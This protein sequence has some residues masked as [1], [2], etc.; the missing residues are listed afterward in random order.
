ME[1]EIVELS[2]DSFTD[3]FLGKGEYR[4]KT[5][6]VPGA[7][8]GERIRGK[9]RSREEG[10]LIVEPTEILESSPDR[11]EPE[12]GHF[13][14]CGGCQLQHVAYDRQ[15]ALKKARFEK[16]FRERAPDLKVDINSVIPSDTPYRY[17]NRITLHGPGEPG[18]WQVEGMDMVR[19]EEC[20][21]TLKHLENRLKERRQSHFHSYLEKGIRNVVIRAS[22]TGEVF[23][24]REN[25]DVGAHHAPV[26]HEE[27]T[28]PVT[29]ETLTFR[30]P[31]RSFW[32]A[33]AHMVSKLVRKVADYVRTAEA[34]YLLDAYAGVGLFGLTCAPLVES[35]VCVEVDEKSLEEA[36]KN[37]ERFSVD[38]VE[39]RQGSAG[40]HLPRLL[41]EADLPDT[42]L[43]VDPPRDGI[44][45]FLLRILRERRPSSMVYVS[46]NPSS[47]AEELNQ[48][49]G[50]G[51]YELEEVVG[52]DQFPQT[53]HLESIAFL[54]G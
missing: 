10:R 6:L 52:I 34:S 46:C 5:T 23:D 53:R 15:V 45:N 18:F 44:S 38:H 13:P 48:L 49:V 28:H 31:A 19:I 32:Q 26:L 20:P 35:A 1:E 12:C 51:P 25:P 39:F 7:L 33:H 37:A 42:V 16:I 8:P 24:G 50:N 2:I 43:V 9:I 14:L 30:V 21:I 17:R 54:R 11:V 41:H 3:R 27:L 4:G 47:Q 22:N 29:G 40:Q 36:R